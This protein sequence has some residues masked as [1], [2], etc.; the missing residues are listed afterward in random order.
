MRERVSPSTACI[1]IR[2]PRATAVRVIA[3]SSST[4]SSS[5]MELVEAVEIVTAE[6][7]DL[8]DAGE[9]EQPVAEVGLGKLGQRRVVADFAARDPT[10][11]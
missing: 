6:V 4:A 7:N 9:F 3:T 5:T 2:Q 11:R 1:D 10:P 8:A